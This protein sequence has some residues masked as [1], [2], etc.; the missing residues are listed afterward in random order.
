MTSVPAKAD[1]AL[2][3]LRGR[4][5]GVLS[6]LLAG[7]YFGMLVSSVAV[8][9]SRRGG[10]TMAIQTQTTG[11]ANPRRS[12]PGDPGRVGWDMVDAFVVIVNSVDRAYLEDLSLAGK[13][14][15]LLSHEEPGLALP[16]VVADNTGGV[17]AAIQHLLWHGHRS[18]AFAGDLEQSDIRQRYET[19]RTTLRANGIDPDPA[20]NYATG[21]NLVHGG[22]IAG[23]RMIDAG[24][25]S[26]AVFAAT[27]HNA[28]GIMA[29]LK[30]RGCSVPRPGHR[31]LRR[32]P[33]G[34][35]DQSRPVHRAP[36][37]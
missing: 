1:P 3:S 29:V 36:A 31:R 2:P 30:E 5:I 8:A 11:P 12:R 22:R 16:V 17:R 26:T 25:P 24:L 7:H 27:D 37:L 10:R 14:L 19:Y 13:P 28:A 32:R 9:V 35:N 4:T 6:S 34:R 23:E 33:F 15:V 18:I 21:D 20:L